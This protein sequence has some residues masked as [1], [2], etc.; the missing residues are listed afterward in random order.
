MLGAEH[1][2]LTAVVVT[3][4]AALFD[5]RTGR[6]P[7]WLTLGALATA[8]LA[9]AESQL[10][11]GN[12]A[13]AL[14]ALGISIAGALACGLIPWLLWR[15][16]AIGGGDVKLFAAVGA[17]CRPVVGI[18]AEL[19]A[20]IAGMLIAPAMLAY[21]GKLFRTMGNS[22][23]L[24]GNLFRPKS[25]RKEVPRELMTKMRFGPAIFLGTL[26]AVALR[27]RSL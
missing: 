7:D 15:V 18:E 3:A 16:E 23:A 4:T 5:W 8:P 14:S 27:W 26:A 2:L 11:S 19:Y 13:N 25:K 20:F 21:E 10:L 22:L 24:F 17:L 9:Q 1:F 12:G 6:I